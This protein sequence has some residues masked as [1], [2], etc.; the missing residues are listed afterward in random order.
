M[1]ALI[2]SSKCEQSRSKS[3]AAR[4]SHNFARGVLPQL[5][6]LLLEHLT[7]QSEELDDDTW[8]AAMASGSC[9]GLLATCTQDNVVPHVLPFVQ[10]NITSADWRRREAATLAFGAILEGPTP[11]KLATLVQQAFPLLLGQMTDRHP[12]VKDTAA[13]TLGIL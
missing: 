2:H 9:L 13:W 10:A 7:H 3:T 11:E 6:P 4:T 1:D 5:M 12:V 8:S